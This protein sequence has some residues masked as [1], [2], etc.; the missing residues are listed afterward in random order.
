[1]NLA[2]RFFRADNLLSNVAFTWRRFATGW[3]R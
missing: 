3:Q 1:M 2:G